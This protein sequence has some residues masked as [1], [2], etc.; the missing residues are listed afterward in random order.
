MITDPKS[1]DLWRKSESDTR[2]AV[3]LFLADAEPFKILQ[4]LRSATAAMQE[5]ERRAAGVRVQ[6][7]VK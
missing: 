2:D 3:N 5:F 1:F 7:D 4:K 6:Q